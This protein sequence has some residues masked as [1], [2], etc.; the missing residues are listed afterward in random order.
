MSRRSRSVRSAPI[1]A[2]KGAGLAAVDLFERL[3]RARLSAGFPDEVAHLPAD[4][5]RGA[6]A[7]GKGQTAGGGGLGRIMLG[8]HLERQG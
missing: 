2:K 6:G 7:P 4:H 3:E 8:E 5:A 1:S